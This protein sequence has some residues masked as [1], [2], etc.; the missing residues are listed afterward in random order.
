MNRHIKWAVLCLSLIPFFLFVDKSSAISNSLVIN[1]VQ[2]G[3]SLSASN[4]FIELRNNAPEDVDVTDWCIYYASSANVTN[5]SKLNCFTVEHESTHV[6]VPGDMSVFFISNTF[7]TNY[8]DVGFDIKFGTGLSG[9]GGHIRIIDNQGLVIDKV[10][11]G[12]AVSPESFAASV[13][14]A[15][16]V[17]S[18]L[19][20]SG[21]KP[22]DTDN[23]LLDFSSTEPGAVHPY[24]A[25]YE[26][27]DLC[28]N[29]SGIQ[30]LMPEGMMADEFGDCVDIPIDVC[31]NI[32]GLQIEIPIGMGLDQ[33]SDCVVDVCGN[34]DG[35][36][37]DI[38]E[39]LV[40]SDGDQCHLPDVC[41]NI[42]D[43]Q[44]DVPVGYYFDETSG[45]CL[46]DLPYIQVNEILP[47]PSGSDAGNEFIEIYN[48]NEVSVNLDNYKLRFGS[49]YIELPVGVIIDPNS[50]FVIRNDEI[51]FTLTNTGSNI[52]LWTLDDMIMGEEVNYYSAP[53][54]ETWSYFS[55]GWRYTNRPTPG[56][57][58][59]PR[60]IEPKILAASVTSQL[61]PCA[62]N[63]YRNPETNRC[64]LIST[65]GAVLVPCKVGQ[66]RS[67]TTNRCRNIASD[68]AVLA[69]CDD[70]QERNPET[71]RCRNIVSN[72]IPEA[73]FAV[74]PFYDSQ[75]DPLQW[76]SLG[77]AF[78]VVVFYAVWEWR[79][80][81]KKLFSR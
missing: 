34:I 19:L 6:F 3:D 11:W 46:L 13:P 30:D 50:Y 27:V 61:K 36:Q 51:K 1:Q 14:G 56:D 58:N 52:S 57:I 67:E 22:Q 35:I 79:P 15:G 16:M 9:T 62:A 24:G 77:F 73:A 37:S 45:K 25:L 12:S 65:V 5:G 17:L 20:D 71:N 42:D 47:N 40:I 63:Q 29:I 76:A 59:L 32:A 38:P 74:E 80:E 2:L 18:R 44:F 69:A 33:N 70:N 66:Y 26:V 75:S 43:L 81:I 39:G 21:N 7:N 23:N 54:G 10:G 8:A 28:L 55:D 64:R 49:K 60:L 53:D 41:I 31:Q 78:F 4:E 68:A 48:P 72:V